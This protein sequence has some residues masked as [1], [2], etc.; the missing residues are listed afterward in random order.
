[1]F[2]DL[3][4]NVATWITI[5][6]AINAYDWWSVAFASLMTIFAIGNVVISDERAD[7]QARE[8]E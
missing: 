1:M 2:S 3:A 4:E 5:S 8:D 6:M 7:V